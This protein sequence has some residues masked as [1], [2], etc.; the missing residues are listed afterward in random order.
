MRWRAGRRKWT[1]SPTKPTSCVRN[2][3]TT[4]PLTSRPTS[5][6]SCQNGPS[7]CPSKCSIFFWRSSWVKRQTRKR[8]H[9]KSDLYNTGFWCLCFVRHNLFRDVALVLSWRR[10][11]LDPV[12]RVDGFPVFCVDR[13]NAAAYLHV[14]GYGKVLRVSDDT[15]WTFITQWTGLF[16]VGLTSD[17][18]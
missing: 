6:T 9:H 10:R 1:T 7:F 12:V 14:C 18:L 2:T 15:A 8:G 3:K 13:S 4:T 16:R 5:R 11:A 17:G